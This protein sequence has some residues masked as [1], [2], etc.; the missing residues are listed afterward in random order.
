[1][2]VLSK[3]LVAKTSNITESTLVEMVTMNQVSRGL[4][5]LFIT[6]N[7]MVTFNVKIS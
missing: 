7:L 5:M 6:A 3:H 1:M 4:I 2:Q